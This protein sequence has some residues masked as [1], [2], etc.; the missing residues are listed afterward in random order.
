VELGAYCT[1]PR[2]TTVDAACWMLA[3]ISAA[4]QLKKYLY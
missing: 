1:G 3:C 4:L 2:Q